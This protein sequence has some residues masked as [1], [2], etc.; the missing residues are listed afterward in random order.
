MRPQRFFPLVDHRLHGRF[1]RH[2][3]LEGEAIATFLAHLRRGFLSEGEGA[4]HRHDPGA[5]LREAQAGGAAV[6]EAGSRALPCADDDCG[7]VFQPH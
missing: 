3:G 2:V 7:F 6:A 5:L 4:V 1:L